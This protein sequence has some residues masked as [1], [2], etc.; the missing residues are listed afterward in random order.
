MVRSLPSY[1]NKNV[2]DYVICVC[3]GDYCNNE[4]SLAFVDGFI[5]FPTSDSILYLT[6]IEE[7]TAEQQP[8]QYVVT[9]G[10]SFVAV[11]MLMLFLIFS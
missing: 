4:H 8:L 10:R 2:L 6:P 1:P 9:S 7:R 11:P 3:K 5:D